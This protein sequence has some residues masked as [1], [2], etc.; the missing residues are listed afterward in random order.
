MTADPAVRPVSRSLTRPRVWDVTLTIAA[1]GALG[2]LARYAVS[3]AWPHA[4]GTFPWA[5]FAINVVGCLLIGSLMAVLAE[6]GRP[7]RLVRPFLGVGV[8]GGFTTFS[9]YTVD[10]ERL[11]SAGHPAL[12]L[13]D[14]L[15]TLAAALLAVQLGIVAARLL[16]RPWTPRGTRP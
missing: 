2:A 8:L 4:P 5:T 15:G 10:V 12:A 3:I 16:A 13:A 11:I 7:H 1:G 6:V 9:T 14:L